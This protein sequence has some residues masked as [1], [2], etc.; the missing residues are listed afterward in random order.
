MTGCRFQLTPLTPIHIGTGESLEPFEY[1]I[2]GDQLYRFTLDDLMLALPRE[3]QAHFVAAVE[4]S[5][6]ATRRFVAEQVVA[7]VKAARYTATVSPAARAFYDG[8]MAGDAHPEVA[9]TMRTDDRLYIPGSSLK[10]ALRTALL[11]HAMNKENPITDARRLEQATFAF[12]QVQEDP[13]RAFK[14]GDGAPLDVKARVRVAAVNTKRGGDWDEDVGLLVETIPGALFDNVEPISEHA[15]TFD[16]TFYKYH[17][18]AFPLD[19]ATVL[20]ACRDFYGAH[21][22]A[23]RN[24]LRDLSPAAAAYDALAEQAA[25]L[26]AH[27]C[28][29]RLG[30]GSGYEATT[31]AYALDG[32][33]QPRSRRL[34]EEKLPLGWAELAIVDAGGRPVPVEMPVVA[35]RIPP[36]KPSK[37]A[38]AGQRPRQL[39]D[40]REGMELEGTVRRIEAYGAFVDVGV[41]RDG[42]IHISRLSTGRVNR[43]EDVVKAGDRV[44]VRVL[45]VDAERQ[46]IG[47]QLLNKLTG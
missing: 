9:T 15:V 46:R 47:L 25:K 45:S 27:A 30:W 6:P 17:E 31:V 23:E 3:A 33:K 19:A 37:P 11:Y 42:L 40:L 34:T 21:L 36:A 38:P 10:G 20:A 4:R 32:A 39:A 13:F 41:R 43:V 8:R 1:V 14:V 24:Y 2:A 12:R 35:A 29:V 5:V 22:A 44:R 16:A 28:L 26:P 7:A 18:D